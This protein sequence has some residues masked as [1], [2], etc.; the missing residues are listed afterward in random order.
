MNRHVLL[1]VDSQLKKLYDDKNYTHLITENPGHNNIKKFIVLKKENR[2]IRLIYELD[3]E[4]FLINSTHD[5]KNKIKNLIK[6]L[7]NNCFD[8]LVFKNIVYSHII[9]IH[10]LIDIIEKLPSPYDFKWDYFIKTDNIDIILDIYRLFK[11][12][13][14]ENVFD[15]II[16]KYEYIKVLTDNGF[17]SKLFIIDDIKNTSD[18]NSD[19]INKLGVIYLIKMNKLGGIYTDSIYNFGNELVNI[20]NIIENHIDYP[21]SSIELG[22]FKKSKESED[23]D[24]II[25]MYS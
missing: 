8:G 9:Y 14:N 2:H 18:N 3:L 11:S 7:V 13:N 16:T 22:E 17:K 12:N 4:N 21:T 24:D 5:I 1:K 15:G 19:K 23:L 10:N 6:T 25:S 20:K